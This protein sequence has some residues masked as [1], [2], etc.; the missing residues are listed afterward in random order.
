MFGQTLQ[1]GENRML[2]ND[3]DDVLQQQWGA[4]YF[5]NIRHKL[6]YEYKIHTVYPPKEHIFAALKYT[7]YHQV[8]VVVLGQ[9]PYHGPGQ[10]HGLSFSVCKDTPIPPSLK[11]I[12]KELY[13][14]LGISIPTH[15]SL[16]CW[17][18]QGV[19]L[20]NAVLTVRAGQ[21][22]S[23][24]DI[25]WETFTDAVI[26]A[27]NNR[28]CPVVFMFWGSY[29]QRKGSFVNEQRH[30]ILNASHPSPLAAY[31]GFL[32]SKPFS[33]AN[34]FLISRGINPIDW[35]IPDEV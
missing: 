18:K 10:A 23:H 9:D 2:G 14:D 5:Q 12:Y 21:P 24:Q 19:L 33:K 17:A 31:R 8:K 35:S 13:S 30:C 32:G 1:R 22:S 7:S 4:A 3:W 26:S 6:A 15:G 29:A 11:N 16:V 34:T 27:L 25:G 28:Q 20:L